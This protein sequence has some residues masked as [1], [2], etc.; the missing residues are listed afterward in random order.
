MNRNHIPEI[1]HYAWHLIDGPCLDS[2]QVRVPAILADH[3]LPR[4]QARVRAA[5]RH[6]G[7]QRPALA[8]PRAGLHGGSVSGDTRQ[9]QV[10]KVRKR[11][12]KHHDTW[13]QRRI[14]G[15]SF[16]QVEV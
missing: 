10:R 15:A 5:G 14:L 1:L 8:G 2:H 6:P 13:G 9:Q 11:D 16:V 4:V 3:A 12:P 7:E